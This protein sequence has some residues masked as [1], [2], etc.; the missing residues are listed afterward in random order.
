MHMCI[1]ISLNTHHTAIDF[2]IFVWMNVAVDSA[3]LSQFMG[4]TLPWVPRGQAVSP[5]A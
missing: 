4:T 2:C 1:C 5:D 3:I